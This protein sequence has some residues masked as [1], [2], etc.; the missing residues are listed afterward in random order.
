[1]DLYQIW[2]RGSSRGRY[3]FGKFGVIK[4]KFNI[5]P[6]FVPKNCQILAENT[7][8]LSFFRLKMGALKSKLP[9]IIIVAP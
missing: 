1:M 4:L 3:T 7:L 2:F 5:K 8:D 6:L 9:L